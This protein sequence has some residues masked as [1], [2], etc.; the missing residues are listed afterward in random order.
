MAFPP[1]KMG[2]LVARVPIVQGGMGV[3]VSLAGLTAAVAERGGVGVIS[4]AMIGIHEPDVRKDCEGANARALAREIREAQKRT[5]G[6]LG[7]NIMVA[8]THFANLV[9]TSVQEGI[10]IIF[11]GAGLPLD[12]PKF[13]S[14]EMRE[15]GKGPKLVPIISSA[16]AAKVIT[17]K[18]LSRFNYL[19]DGFVVE[20][21]LAGGHLGFKAEEL[22]DPYFALEKL[23]PEVLAAV[24]PFED[25]AGRAIPVIPAGGIYTGGDIR[26]YLDMGAAAVQMGTRF[27]ATEECD[28]DQAFKDAYVN[29][30][31]D[32]TIII[33]SPVGMPGRALK[34]T[35]LEDVA[36]GERK[37]FK[38][39]YHCVHTCDLEKSPYCI[40]LALVSAK[41][42]LLDRGF[43][44]AGANVWRVD[45]ITT[46]AE[47][48]D[49]LEQE[50]DASA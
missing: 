32:D 24:K 18:W 5:K 34:N 30:T 22:D 50:Y 7:V 8:L 4:A 29:A 23:V 33:K 36:K 15:S 37:P 2:D 25:K 31:K 26:K 47:L 21:P 44:F 35:F 1:L 14:E 16:R 6:V 46:V 27:V 13:L 42:G 38:C 28:A 49:E 10:D 39:P 40:S 9:K 45:K 12:L 48:V 20:G 43:A 11:A 41:R 3:G 17:K 19:P